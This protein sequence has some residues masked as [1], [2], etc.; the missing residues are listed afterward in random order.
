MCG[1]LSHLR[2]VHRL[3]PAALAN[4]DLVI[5]FIGNVQFL[6]RHCT[7]IAQVMTSFC[8]RFGNVLFGGLVFDSFPCLGFGEVLCLHESLHLGSPCFEQ[9]PCSL[10]AF[11]DGRAARSVIAQ[12]DA[13]FAVA[14]AGDDAASERTVLRAD[15]GFG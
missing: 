1:S 8:P 3:T 15:G 10:F 12:V 13:L 6:R 5:A 7:G 2:N 9:L 14:E 4:C 11:G